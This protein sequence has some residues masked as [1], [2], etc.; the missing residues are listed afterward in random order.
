MH[1]GQDAFDGETFE[2]FLEAA[3]NHRRCNINYDASHFIK[4]GL[5]HVESIDFHRTRIKAFHVKDA[6]FRPTGRQGFCSGYRPWL[7]RAARDH[8]LGDGQVDFAQIF[9]KMTEYDFKGW[10]VH[11]WED[12]LEH[13]EEAP[14]QGA[15]FIAS[16]IFRDTDK[17]FDEFAATGL[18]IKYVREILGLG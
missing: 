2:H 1:P 13:P 6:E 4:Q 12:C 15:S 3:E 16:H 10:A 11:E 9:S 8:S 14:A 17:V 18:S 5:D 7:K